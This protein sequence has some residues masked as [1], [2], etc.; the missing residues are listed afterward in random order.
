MNQMN[1]RERFLAVL[2]SDSKE[3]FLLALGHRLGISAREIFAEKSPGGLQQA[4]ACNEMTIAIWSQV[5]A[6]KDELG[7]GY[8]DSEFLVI[9]LGKADMGDARTHL[10]NAVESALL[11]IAG[12]ETAGSGRARPRKC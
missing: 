7:D 5:R 8:P 2:E 11:S 12:D 10:R 9:L 3:T 6:M 4:Q 1:I